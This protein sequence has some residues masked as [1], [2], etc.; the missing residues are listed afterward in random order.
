MTVKTVQRILQLPFAFLPD[1]GERVPLSPLHVAAPQVAL[2]VIVALRLPY[3]VKVAATIPVMTTVVYVATHTTIGTPSE[4][5]GFGSAFLSLL[6]FNASL[7]VWFTDP[8]SEYRYVRDANTAPLG[9]RGL[10][11]RVYNVLCITLNYRLIGWNTQVSNVPTP[12]KDKSAFIFHRLYQLLLTM[13]VLDVAQSHLL[14]NAPVYTAPDP[15]RPTLLITWA[16]LLCSYSVIKLFYTVASLVAVTLGLSAP[17][18]WPDLFGHWR[19]A[20]TLRRLWGR[21]WHQLLRRHFS[22]WGTAAVR[23]LGVRRGT[24]LSS[25]VQLHTAFA[26]SAAIH[27]FGDAMVGRRLVGVSAPFFIANGLA[28]AVEDAV[29]ALGRWLCRGEELKG[30]EGRPPPLALRVAGYVW[31]T[32]AMSVL[33]GT[34][35]VPA[36]FAL[37]MVDKPTLPFSVVGWMVA[38][39]A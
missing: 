2:I 19:D 24:W 9:A 21:A 14:A 15:P 26:V 30:E 5:Y 38:K 33:A 36:Q 20:Y 4:H 32:A 27:T 12:I 7:F 35:F 10:F 28:I 17:E 37:E 16:F 34:L 39:S 8:M 11:S 22:A 25:Q 18:D 31:A 13:L 3:Y 23:T 6:F 1:D 29:L